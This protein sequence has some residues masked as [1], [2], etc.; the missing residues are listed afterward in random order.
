MKLQEPKDWCHAHRKEL[1]VFGAVV[2][3]ATGA[4]VYLYTVEG[5]VYIIVTG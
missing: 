4:G 1:I 3:I 5:G 2:V